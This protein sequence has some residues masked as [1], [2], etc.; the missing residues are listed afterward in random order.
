MIEQQFEDFLIYRV[1][2][3]LYNV[4]TKKGGFPIIRSIM[5]YS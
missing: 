4:I 5:G 1:T 3:D 2:I